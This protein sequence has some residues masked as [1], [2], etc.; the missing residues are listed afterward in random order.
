MFIVG[1]ERHSGH[2]ADLAP[3]N[4]SADI[5]AF[6]LLHIETSGH[7]HRLALF[8][9]SVNTNLREDSVV[10]LTILIIDIP[11][12]T[13]L[14]GN[15]SALL[16]SLLFGDLDTAGLR[17]CVTNLLRHHPALLYRFLLTQLHWLLD[18]YREA[19]LPMI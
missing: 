11:P 13:H 4:V 1:A 17:L 2:I 8:S 5:V 12:P 19:N 3:V 9:L 18:L 10:R 16:A 14:S 7:R 6:L 15:I